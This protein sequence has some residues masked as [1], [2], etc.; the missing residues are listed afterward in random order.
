MSRP[1]R[2]VLSLLV[3]L[4]LFSPDVHALSFST[5]K[6]HLNPR[7]LKLFD[8]QAVTQ[9]IGYVMHTWAAK[10][11]HSSNDV[12]FTNFPTLTPQRSYSVVATSAHGQILA[13]AVA[14]GLGLRHLRQN[15]AV[16]R[17]I[18]SRQDLAALIEAGN[19]AEVEALIALDIGPNRETQTHVK[20]GLLLALK[21]LRQ[22]VGL[23]K[24]TAESFV[25]ERLFKIA[26]NHA[27]S[28][29]VGIFPG[30]TMAKQLD[31]LTLSL[32]TEDLYA[33]LSVA[34]D[35]L[36]NYGLPG[37]EE[38]TKEAIAE[39]LHQ[40][41]L[42][43]AEYNRNVH[44]FARGYFNKPYAVANDSESAP[45][46]AEKRLTTLH[47]SAIVSLL[48][49]MLIPRGIP[50]THLAYSGEE[51]IQ[52]GI[53]RTPQ[54]TSDELRDWMKK[55]GGLPIS[56]K[57][58][59]EQVADFFEQFHL[60]KTSSQGSAAVRT[61]ENE[62]HYA[63]LNLLSDIQV[64]SEEKRMVV[65][66]QNQRI[67]EFIFTPTPTE[68]AAPFFVENTQ[69][70]IQRTALGNRIYVIAPSGAFMIQR[71]VANGET[72]FAITRRASLTTAP[73]PSPD[74]EPESS[75]IPASRLHRHSILSAA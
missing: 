2:R 20:P 61:M 15:D 57:Q 43:H 72:Q 47:T 3:I 36:L 21:T 41:T 44:N 10:A 51:R 7:S 63:E 59:A 62:G 33:A 23:T 52:S 68:A 18:E 9:P 6:I 42:R 75:S 67:F 55:E 74:R 50:I 60:W 65:R 26:F 56:T 46:K 22:T 48:A 54:F 14:G 13:A 69:F 40:I 66:F 31:E 73:Q 17:L 45:Q 32:L 70:R 11:R 12:L 24:T 64:V 30:I 35:F 27:V 4:A 58:D 49:L 28:H 8:Q 25:N 53:T 37:C 5:A 38:P 71:V 29:T 1:K 34:R 16:K 19:W 39:V